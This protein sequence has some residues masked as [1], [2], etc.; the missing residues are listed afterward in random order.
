MDVLEGAG[1]G[2]GKPRSGK[3]AIGGLWVGMPGRG[4]CHHGPHAIGGRRRPGAAMSMLEEHA[5]WGGL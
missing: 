1:G 5:G 2:P 4:V 3:V